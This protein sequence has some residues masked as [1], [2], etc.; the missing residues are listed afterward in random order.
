MLFGHYRIRLAVVGI[1]LIVVT[2]LYVISAR[3]RNIEGIGDRM[4]VFPPAPPAGLRAESQEGFVKVSWKGGGT[5]TVRDYDLARTPTGLR[6]LLGH[7]V[8]LKKM[9]STDEDISFEDEDVAVG[10]E[11]VYVVRAVDVYGQS[12]GDAKIQIRY[13]PR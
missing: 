10:R 5:D 9:T 1:I 8:G 13:E 12:S 2:G 4:T 3:T 6:W 11:Y 7:R